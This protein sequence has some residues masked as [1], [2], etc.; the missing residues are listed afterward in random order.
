MN[1]TQPIYDRNKMKPVPKGERQ[2]PEDRMLRAAQA[3]KTVVTMKL[4]DGR[5]IHGVISDLSKFSLVI[6]DIF[7]MK[8][9]ILTVERA[10]EGVGRG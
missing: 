6:E 3:L 9:A 8:H 2:E 5:Y 7:V 1:R 4:I 10:P